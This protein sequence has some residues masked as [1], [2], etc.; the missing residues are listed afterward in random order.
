MV[1]NGNLGDFSHVDSAKSEGFVARLDEMH[2]LSSFQDYKRVAFQLLF[3]RPGASIA[4]VGCGTGD[5]ARKLADQV[6][7][8]GEVVGFDIS[9]AMLSEARVRHAAVEGL[10]FMEAS[11][12]RLPVE[13]ER[14]D[15]VRADR[16]L[17]HV[18]DPTRTL[19]EMVRVAKVGGRVVVS[20][21]DMAGCWV[22]S[23]DDGIAQRVMTK[24][25]DSCRTPTLPRRLYPMFHDANLKD[26]VLTVSPVTAFSAAAVDKILNISG[27]V[28]ALVDEEEL[29]PEA[30]RSWMESIASRDGRGQFVAGLSIMTVAGTKS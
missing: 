15:A 3:P 29:S 23:G 7:P 19:A 5:D 26:V 16:V 18:P 8:G 17:I 10:S 20:E 24:I 21:P 11:S 6:A 2:A 30:A 28:R 14:F 1:E 25:S 27:V 22:A 12:D 13:D 4:D 9:A